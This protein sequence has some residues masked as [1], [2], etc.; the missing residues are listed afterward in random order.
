MSYHF[1]EED[2]D[3]AS[4]S[5]ALS[6]SSFDG[7]LMGFI[8]FALL[9]ELDYWWSSLVVAIKKQLQ[10]EGE[11]L[12]TAT[13]KICMSTM[14]LHIIFILSDVSFFFGRHE[15]ILSM[16]LIPLFLK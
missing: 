4:S 10:R 11:K 16:L 6:T 12:L 1:E 9:C 7:R 15:C 5:S 8:R 13:T 3:E 2:D 14:G